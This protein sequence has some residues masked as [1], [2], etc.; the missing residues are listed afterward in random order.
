M[1]FNTQRKAVAAVEG[2]GKRYK[3]F[4]PLCMLAVLCIALFCSAV[5][6]VDMALSDDDGRFLGMNRSHKKRRTVHK[7]E[8]NAAVP[9]TAEKKGFFKRA[10]S[11]FLAFCFAVMVV[12]SGL[13]IVSFAANERYA[14]DS[15]LDY[16]GG[17]LNGFKN[18]TA[19]HTYKNTL[20]VPAPAG[21]WTSIG[22]NKFQGSSVISSID[23]T[24]VQ[25]IEAGAFKNT[26][27]LTYVII[28]V[29][30]F[31][32]YTSDSDYYFYKSSANVIDDPFQGLSA[33]AKIYIKNSS[34]YMD[35]VKK[36]LGE[37]FLNKYS[38][39]IEF[40]D[41]YEA[42]QDV[43]SVTVAPITK[44]ATYA[45]VT[46]KLPG[47]STSNPF[48][49][50]KLYGAKEGP[51]GDK[52]TGVIF[53]EI[54]EYSI[55]E[56]TDGTDETGDKI[57][58]ID[59][60]SNT[61][62]IRVKASSIKSFNSIGA[63]LYNDTHKIYSDHYAWSDTGLTEVTPLEQNLSC[64][65]NGLVPTAH[66]TKA[67]DNLK[68]YI[69]TD[70]S[71]DLNQTALY[72]KLKDNSDIL[73]ENSTAGTSWISGD[74]EEIKYPNG[75][76]VFLLEIYDPLNKFSE[77]DDM[78]D[79]AHRQ[80][81][82]NSAGDR[83]SSVTSWENNGFYYYRA[84]K[85]LAVATQFP[86]VE[87]TG[88]TRNPD[89]ENEIVFTWKP[90]PVTDGLTADG[91]N[92]YFYQDSANKNEPV[93]Y[94]NYH[95]NSDGTI[96]ATYRLPDG[97]NGGNYYYNITA[98]KMFNYA[99][100]SGGLIP[101][102]G[103]RSN[104]D[105]SIII[106]KFELST[107]STEP[108]TIV[109]KWKKPTLPPS[110]TNS[111]ATNETTFRIDYS[112][113][114][115]EGLHTG[116]IAAPSVTLSGGV[117]SAEIDTQDS[118]NA[119]DNNIEYTFTVSQTCTVNNTD[120][121]HEHFFTSN[122]AKAMATE[123]PTFTP[124]VEVKDGNREFTVKCSV[125]TDDNGK[126][127]DDAGNTL[128]TL[129]AGYRV[130]VFDRKSD[131]S[132]GTLLHDN[133]IT[134]DGK[135]Y[136][137]DLVI[138]FNQSATGKQ[139]P[140][141]SKEYN[142][143]VYPFYHS[144]HDN[145]VTNYTIDGVKLPDAYN[146]AGYKEYPILG[147]IYAWDVAAP[148]NNLTLDVEWGYGD[149]PWERGA[150]LKWRTVT[151]KAK[152]YN[153]Y[154][155]RI[156]SGASDKEKEFT[157][158]V[159]KQ[160]AKGMGQ[161]NI[162][163]D[164]AAPFAIYEDANNTKVKEYAQFEYKVVAVYDDGSADPKPAFE[165][166]QFERSMVTLSKPMELRTEGRD[167][168]ITISWTSV[169]SADKYNIYRD[170]VFLTSVYMDKA[171]T[172][173][174]MSYVDEPMDNGKP[175]TYTVTS[176][177]TVA[178][179]DS[180]DN[181]RRLLLESVEATEDGTSGQYFPPVTG[182][183]GT[184]ADGTITV[185]WDK[186]PDA[187]VKYY[188]LTAYRYDKNGNLYP[189]NNPQIINVEGTSYTLDGLTNGD[190]YKFSVEA[191]K[192]INQQQ[193]WKSSP[194]NEKA[195][196]VGVPI[197]PPT[198]QAAPG[199]RKVILTWD[200]NPQ[201]KKAD[202]Y[203]I[204][205]AESKNGAQPADGDYVLVA[206]TTKTTY[207]DTNLENGTTY[208]YKIQ[209]YKSVSW[210]TIVSDDSIPVHATP[211]A[212]YAEEGENDPYYLDV[213]MDFNVTAEDGIAHLSWTE[214]SGAEGYRIYMIDNY[215]MPVLLGT[216]SKNK[217]DY[218]GLVNGEVYT[219]TVT[220]YKT[221]ANGEIVESGFAIPKTVTIGSYLAAP[222]DVAAVAG[223]SKVTLSW[224][225]VTGA[226][227][228]VVYA[229]S[230]A[231]NS[232]TAIAVVSKPGF[233]HENLENGLTYS[234]M[235]VAY[236]T[237]G[238]SNQYSQ[239]SLAVSATPHAA[240]DSSDSGNGN[241]N[242]GNNNGGGNNGGSGSNNSSN[243]GTDA[244]G[245]KINIVGTVPEGISHSE[246]I[247]AYSDEMAFDQDIDIRFSVNTDTSKVIYDIL[248]GYADGLDSFDVYPFDISAYIAGTT[249][250][251]Q[252]AVG[253][254]VTVTMPVPD[255]FRNYGVDYQVIHVNSDGQMEVLALTYGEANGI[256]LVQ[257]SVS[258][259]SPF[260]FVHYYTPEDLE[261][262]SGASAS[263]TVNTAAAGSMYAL[264]FTGGRG[265]SLRR[266]NRVYKLIKK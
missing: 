87:I 156:D 178:I 45:Y 35:Q 163:L 88:V 216:S 101:F 23:L 13:E 124:K 64:T 195:I 181:N 16:S 84:T 20:D 11:G 189:D 50:I 198:V 117:F 168:K 176:V 140:E 141:N 132:N 250:K 116:S 169:E 226:T 112:Y 56:L 245:Y 47:A 225:A 60:A 244:S 33:D 42:P 142:V 46:V 206:S 53:S 138:E 73:S 1:D 152:Y 246:L 86:E 265:Y 207:T 89:C 158:L 212:I 220:A 79:D 251:V 227:G 67:A 85:T 96:S 221:L 248:S 59:S 190:T 72:K 71:N 109:L 82:F 182:L 210:N 183:D 111:Y 135:G 242:G 171:A 172:N 61:Y 91:Y 154:R 123:K 255:S 104:S 249:T 264:R 150:L 211:D 34:G 162:Y 254:Y 232:F 266:R 25:H 130:V 17:V 239:Y 204:S 36:Y 106:D 243:N 224:T 21:K 259:F 147:D 78:F 253:H 6:A 38:G 260:A 29:N 160:P 37:S 256:P 187:E 213:P 159:F 22:E 90:V 188:I 166:F 179:D 202:G 31:K 119:L 223:D 153:I 177:Y 157:M 127:V 18:L 203:Y 70:R 149:V 262:R 236:K 52:V 43:E 218:S 7:R 155:K 174:E 8:K 102:E 14:A 167:G 201:S 184:T 98:Y 113:E 105:K 165:T 63:R 252:P 103:A 128:N 9:V 234:Y 30:D 62:T 235:I 185:K 191:V 99:S 231:K 107:E 205:R 258:E 240:S 26:S 48:S 164:N 136:A 49:A 39:Q 110:N 215:G 196:T 77:S 5:R 118:S 3:I 137:E 94:E 122:E 129:P 146:K 121:K 133:Y 65:Y 27:S 209:A 75:Y 4:Y 95:T 230:A 197:Y 74:L 51:G 247:S 125:P 175:H 143:W 54:K 100:G 32:G 193:E 170:G 24:G 180:N 68:Y 145:N 55:S 120:P 126:P 237:V 92:I 19:D 186:H 200:P 2:F 144:M 115:G 261:S 114:D 219:Y 199:N 108:N 222:V 15:Q 97:F 228:Y 233:V 57:C 134:A 12:P 217:V 263:G 194:S 192:I 161:E 58:A 214:V 40:D 257:F 83:T 238:L 139:A 44:G 80:K 93:V 229:Y 66:F 69:F 131:G 28:D 76:N 81:I 173:I 241:N 148:D 208:W 151:D 41:R 10:V